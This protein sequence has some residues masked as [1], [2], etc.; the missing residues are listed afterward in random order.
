LRPGHCD[1]DDLADGVAHLLALRRRVVALHALGLV[2]GDRARD[3]V[4]HVGLARE[5]L[6]AK[7]VRLSPR[8][9]PDI[10]IRP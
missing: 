4:V 6:T 7:R 1:R 9:D 10:V 3:D 2:A 5:I 8:S